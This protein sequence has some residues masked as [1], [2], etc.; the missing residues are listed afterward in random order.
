MGTEVTTKVAQLRQT[1]G[2]DINWPIAPAEYA[3]TAMNSGL[4]GAK[5][6]ATD[7]AMDVPHTDPPPMLRRRV[8]WTT[9]RPPSVAMRLPQLAQCSGLV[10]ATRHTSG[11]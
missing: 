9:S 3:E 5:L 11:G 6:V 2:L 8:G 10:P 7:R 1:L 4:N